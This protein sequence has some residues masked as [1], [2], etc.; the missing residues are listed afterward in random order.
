MLGRHRYGTALELSL[1]ILTSCCVLPGWCHMPNSGLGIWQHRQ[2]N[3]ASVCW[4]HP[5]VLICVR[6][7][8][9]ARH[10]RFPP[11]S[12][13]PYSCCA[14]FAVCMGVAVCVFQ[15]LLNR[16]LCSISGTSLIVPHGKEAVSHM[17]GVCL[18]SASR[19]AH[20]AYWGSWADCLATIR[21][22]HVNVADTMAAVLS[23]PPASRVLI[24]LPCCSDSPSPSAPA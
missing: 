13:R 7:R 16:L 19:S 2:R 22:R 4:E 15:V 6:P 18:R 5:L 21:A 3:V 11:S 9:S 14:R 1:V 24:G 8:T 20:A 17:G 23:D 12:P 10:R